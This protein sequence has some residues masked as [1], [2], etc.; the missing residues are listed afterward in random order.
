MLKF[1]PL[2]IYGVILKM[3]KRNLIMGLGISVLAIS[4]SLAAT[5]M[6]LRHTDWQD[7]KNYFDI[8]QPG[9]L[10]STSS[11]V[12]Q[13][14][15]V[16]EERSAQ[17]KHVRLQ[18]YYR[19]FMV[20][21]GFAILH[22]QDSTNS[23]LSSNQN[24]SINGEVFQDLSKDL[25]D[26]PN[27]LAHNTKIALERIKQDFADKPIV[28]EK[29]TPMI[30]VDNEN[31]AHW[32]YHIF[33]SIQPN[34]SMPE[35]FNTIV[36]ANTFTKY[37]EWNDIKTINLST[38][39]AKGYGGN[40]KLH[41]YLY[42][43]QYDA[44]VVQRDEKL[45]KCYLQNNIVQVRNMNHSW[46]NR[47]TGTIMAFNCESNHGLYWT[48]VSND[49]LDLINGA[50][51][52][53]NDAAYQ[54]V[55]VHDM[56]KK[57]YGE[58]VLTQNNKPMLLNLRVHF[59][60]QYENAFWDGKQMTFGDGA[61]MFYPL[62][63]IG[64][65]A[66]EISHGFT[67]QHSNLEY[68]GQSG[69]INESFSDMA[70]KAAELYANDTIKNWQIGSEI[71][72]PNQRITALRFMNKPSLD[73]QSIDTAAEYNDTLDVHHSSGVFNRFFYLLATSE[74]WNA[75]K[76]FS[77]MVEANMNYW[78]PSTTFQ[79]ASCGVLDAAKTKGLSLQAIHNA[80]TEV[81]LDYTLC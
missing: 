27:D 54:G 71:V 64:I 4:N 36:D 47:V 1:N 8:S 9:L 77:V 44:L 68:F 78:T 12:N 37:A 38:V 62:V 50:F 74:G 3:F 28:E 59:G 7:V 15:V 2:Y 11:N 75:R 32:A 21:G 80:M 6:S 16:R 52:P 79:E 76:A 48:G 22:G 39:L 53:S 57:W 46:N 35:K 24:V 81:G 66:H 55:V 34:D 60:K 20:H 33:L 58:D 42:G 51:S 18:Q 70:S 23:L 26:V 25:G 29:I 40:P 61:D 65:T 43:N 31:K 69:G 13:I 5:P 41:K 10:K 45:K 49:G 30:F 56:Y 67:E 17:I 14:R 19:G 73:G 72:K 63:S